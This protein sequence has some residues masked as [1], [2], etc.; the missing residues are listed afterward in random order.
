M[1]RFFQQLGRFFRHRLFTSFYLPSLLFAIAI[2]LRIPIL[3]LYARSL[4]ETYFLVGLVVAGAGLGTLIA[5]L[6]AGY[7]L[8]GRDKRLGMM[9]GIGI[10][11]LCTLGLLWARSV[12]L[13]LGLRILAGFGLSVY[14]VARHA[15]ISEAVRLAVRGR[16]LSLFGG[17]MRVGLFIGPAIGGLLGARFGIRFPFAVYFFIC[18][19]AILVLFL[20][21]NHSA[22]ETLSDQPTG[23][24][25]VGLRSALRGR[26][27]VFA[28]ASLA[29]VLAQITRAGQ[30]LI[31]P[32]YAA[33]VLLLAP[34]Q[35]GFVVS[36][37]SAVSMTLFYPVGLIMDRLG[38]KLAIVPSFVLMGLGLALLPF[39][40]GMVSF[41]LVAALLGFGHG[42]GSGTMMTMGSDLSPKKGRSAYLGAWRWIGDAGSSGGPVLV[43]I[44]ADLLALPSAAL[45]IGAVGFL[46]GGVFGVLVPETLQKHPSRE[47]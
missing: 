41:S 17:L 34:D 31:L 23:E 4:T 46:A 21:R 44:V 28:S 25:R 19:L 22:G 10:E 38:R 42:L 35:I 32:L 12:W 33:D 14:G 39:T 2:G 26:L 30:R 13:A 1:T 40:R 36:L 9:L 11:A 20:D 3:P 29:H 16:A 18:C 15:Y 37:S 8:R 5:D 43:G 24:A 7:L 45:V 47:E 6:P 27:G